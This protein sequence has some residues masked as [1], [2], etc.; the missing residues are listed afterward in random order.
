[1]GDAAGADPG[2]LE[3]IDLDM[4][5]LAVPEPKRLRL[6]YQSAASTSH[7]RAAKLLKL[8]K[9]RNEAKQADIDRGRGTLSLVA[10]LCLAVSKLV[11]TGKS[12]HV[13]RIKAAS[14]TVRHF[15]LLGKAIFLPAKHV[16]QVGVRL[17]R[18]ICMAAACFEGRQSTGI[19]TLLA[20][21]RQLM[22]ARPA[23]S[24]QQVHLAYAHLWDEVDVQ[25]RARR[26]KRLRVSRMQVKGSVLVQRGVFQ[27][28]TADL[29]SKQRNHHDELFLIQSVAVD[30]SA[31]GALLPGLRSGMPAKFSF[32]NLPAMASLL[33]S[34]DSV[35]YLPLCDRA[36]GNMAILRHWGASMAR[37]V[38][39]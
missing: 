13:G 1:M 24:L 3:Q 18:A 27:T 36:S 31:G 26:S 30:G 15:A 12:S 28:D 37:S 16:L 11:N 14:L 2:D 7:A 20:T 9:A 10:T 8:E 25:A 35:C 29:K 39:S 17:T 22:E 23:S 34:C 5:E 32:E 21:G 19:D 4:A 38:P 33:R 6:G